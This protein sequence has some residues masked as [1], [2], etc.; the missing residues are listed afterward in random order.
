MAVL[1]C[2]SVWFATAVSTFVSARP[3]L[4]TRLLSVT[5]SPSVRLNRTQSSVA[6]A[7][8]TC[9]RFSRALLR[10][11]HLSVEVRAAAHD[12]AMRA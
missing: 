7:W 8:L 5:H 6:V 10:L 12:V 4:F 2:I 1:H 11:A 9:R 3:V